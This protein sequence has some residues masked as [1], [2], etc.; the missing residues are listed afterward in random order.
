MLDV[1]FGLCVCV[2]VCVSHLI[3]VESADLYC[4]KCVCHALRV[5]P[6]RLYTAN[7]MSIIDIHTV[8]TAAVGLP[9]ENNT[10]S[11][12]LLRCLETC[13]YER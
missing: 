3:N 6:L 8:S 9:C 1:K 11:C 5:K 12:L 13:H 2:C 10:Y 4:I 7:N